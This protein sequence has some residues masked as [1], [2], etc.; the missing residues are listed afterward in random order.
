V[1][2]VCEG[3]DSSLLLKTIG[4]T[5]SFPFSK[6]SKEVFEKKGLLDI[7]GEWESG[8]LTEL[9]ANLVNLSKSAQLDKAAEYT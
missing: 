5:S 2:K 7:I 3:A 1:L 6:K 8:I 9:F 4:V